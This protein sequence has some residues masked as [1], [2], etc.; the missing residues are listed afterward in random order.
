MKQI[1]E[2]ITLSTSLLA[3]EL[4]A[5]DS[6]WNN[7]DLP[8]E[9]YYYNVVFINYIIRL[10]PFLP[11]PFINIIGFYLETLYKFFPIEF[12]NQSF[13]ILSGKILSSI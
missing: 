3:L 12:K 10:F 6:F 13:T 1:F 5:N 4:S 7:V 9:T 8:F 2:P 11:I